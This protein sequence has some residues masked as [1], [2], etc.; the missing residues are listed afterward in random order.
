MPCSSRSATSRGRR[1]RGGRSRSRPSSGSAGSWRRSRQVIGLAGAPL[2][3]SLLTLWPIRIAVY[4]VDLF[5]TG[6]DDY[7]RGDTIFGAVNYGALAWSICLLV[8]GVRAVH[9]W[10]LP[11]A[12]G[13]VAIAAVVPGLIVA[14]STV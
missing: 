9:G 13:A 4:G 6:G 3:L 14:A 5:R 12:L 7:G 8:V 10:T 11:R 1:P 2:A